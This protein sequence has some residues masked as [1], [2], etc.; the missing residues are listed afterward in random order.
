LTLSHYYRRTLFNPA[1]EKY[2]SE[3]RPPVLSLSTARIFVVALAAVWLLGRARRLTAYERLVVIAV[4]AMALVSLR[5]CVWLGL[6]VI[7]VLPRALDEVWPPRR[8]ADRLRLNRLV[9]IAAVAAALVA[10]GLA[11]ARPLSWLGRDWPRA[12]SAAV[13]REAS[14]HPSRCVF[15]TLRFADWLLVEEPTL[16]GR[17]ALDARVELL[18]RLQLRRYVEFTNRIGDGWKAAASGCGVIVLDPV[19]DRQIERSFLADPGVRRLYGDGKVSV[20]VR[21]G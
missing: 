7:V 21:D 4:A 11:A 10:V 6:A 2:I 13:S 8:A 12:A 20:L 5:N 18:S 16:R 15:S 19:A 14:A 1:L 3:W 9:A 17:V